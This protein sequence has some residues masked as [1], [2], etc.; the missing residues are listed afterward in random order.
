MY[1][2]LVPKDPFADAVKYVQ[3]HLKLEA[4]PE[5]YIFSITYTA[6]DP[7]LAANVANSTAKLFIDYMEQ[8][9]QSEGSYALNR[10]RAQLDQNRE[11]LEVS[12][13]RL[14]AF[15]KAHAIFRSDT[16]YDSH[17]KVIAELQTE[18]A[19]LEESHAGLASVTQAISSASITTLAAKRNSIIN[20]L[21]D[22][23]AEL[24]PLPAMERE[25]KELEL[26]E[27]VA[28]GAYEA[29]DREFQEAE[30]KSSYA[31]REVQLVAE[32]VPSQLPSRP[33]PLIFGLA[34]LLTALVLG[35][36]LAFLLEYWNRTIGTIRDVEDFVGVKVLATV[37][38][39]SN[40]SKIRLI[41]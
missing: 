24:K 35:A 21:R 38:R 32:A 15:K 31:A 40:S 5:T 27:K 3:Q 19:K 1:G 4:R 23:Q 41:A 33:T 18:L 11:Q 36:A 14:E 13:Q 7:Q 17:L 12:R 16:E 8:L 28:L 25:I 20:Q 29:I 34:S 37:P 6:K 10:L 26:A 39:V 22:R 2:R 9:R 30:I